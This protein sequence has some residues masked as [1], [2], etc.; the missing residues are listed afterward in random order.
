[1]C[2]IVFLA[3]MHE[4]I[5][6]LGG[7]LRPPAKS[8]ATSIQD[9]NELM[10]LIKSPVTKKNTY[11]DLACRGVYDERIL[12]RLTRVCEDCYELYKEQ[13]IFVLCR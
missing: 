4:C 5:C 13:E 11:V 2:S 3:V 9:A 10:S 6:S 8:S 7:R 1:M 12:T